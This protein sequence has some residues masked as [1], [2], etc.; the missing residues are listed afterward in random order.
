MY[1]I[2]LQQRSLKQESDIYLF[3]LIYFFIVYI[4]PIL[5]FHRLSWRMKKYYKS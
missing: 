1:V 5:N 3:I 2:G 4:P